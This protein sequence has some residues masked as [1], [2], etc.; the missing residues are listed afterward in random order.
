[1]QVLL[2]VDIAASM[3]VLAEATEGWDAVETELREAAGKP[4]AELDCVMVATQVG[5]AGAAGALGLGGGCWRCG[6]LGLVLGQVLSERAV[7][8]AQAGALDAA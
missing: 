7:V 3:A 8:A 2:G 1:M 5:G 6:A 4:V